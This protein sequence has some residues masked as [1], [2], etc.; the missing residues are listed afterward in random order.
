MTPSTG[1]EPALAA[2]EDPRR[3]LD[4]ARYAGKLFAVPESGAD[5]DD[6][7]LGRAVHF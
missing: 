2:G 1:P 6:D 3:H 4:P 7:E 5:R